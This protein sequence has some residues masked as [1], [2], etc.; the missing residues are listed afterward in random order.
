MTEWTN[1]R[2]ID[3]LR[4]IG[5][6]GAPAGARLCSL[7]VQASQGW[8]DLAPFLHWRIRRAGLRLPQSEETPPDRPAFG[9][10]AA[11]WR[12][13]A[14]DPTAAQ[15]IL[16]EI[17]VSSPDRCP[18]DAGALLPQGLHRAIEVWTETELASLHALWWLARLRDHEAWR[19]RVLRAARWHLIHL[20]P[21]N[22]TN[23][24][25]AIHLFAHLA[26]HDGDAEAAMYAQTLLHNCQVHR[27]RP[28]EISSLILIDAAE[29]LAN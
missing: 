21:D 12:A 29:A 3:L 5:S 7:A 17:S 27:G 4:A 6:P 16:D 9:W 8:T 24:P 22:A 20:Q 26:S 1:Q 18:A 23:R 10:D 25:W 19:E 14:G 11:L 28:D 15:V 13:C 2:W